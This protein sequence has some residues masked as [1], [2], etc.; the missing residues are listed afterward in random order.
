MHFTAKGM[1][2]S[3]YVLRSSKQVGE[4]CEGETTIKKYF[5]KNHILEERIPVK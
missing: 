2:G 3:F 4:K 1:I 5:F